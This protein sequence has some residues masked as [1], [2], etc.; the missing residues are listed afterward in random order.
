MLRFIP[1]KLLPLL[2]RELFILK[3]LVNFLP[4]CA[5]LKPNW[6]WLF[7]E[8]NL[9]RIVWYLALI[10]VELLVIGAHSSSSSL[11]S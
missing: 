8:L 9:S 3:E 1:F 10:E 11:G 2:F 6:T 5:Q 4:Y 7:F